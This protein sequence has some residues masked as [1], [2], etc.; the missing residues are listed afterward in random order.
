[1]ATL[2]KS[3]LLIRATPAAH[4]RA[5]EFFKNWEGIK[6]KTVRESCMLLGIGVKPIICNEWV[7][8]SKICGIPDETE[9]MSEFLDHMSDFLQCVSD[10]DKVEKCPDTGTVFEY[11][12]CDGEIHSISLSGGKFRSEAIENVSEPLGLVN[13]G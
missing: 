1:M 7:Y 13:T 10:T 5:Q 9:R 3:N 12:T 11:E 6:P 8:G 4:S 2:L